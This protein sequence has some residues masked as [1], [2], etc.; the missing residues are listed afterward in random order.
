ML[1]ENYALS[2]FM[3]LTLYFHLSAFSAFC[4]FKFILTYYS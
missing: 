3:G 1:I 4:F 2:E